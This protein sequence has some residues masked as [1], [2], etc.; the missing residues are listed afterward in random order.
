MKNVI[1]ERF[2]CRTRPLRMSSLLCSAP[3]AG[4]TKLCGVRAATPSSSPATS[5]PS[6][7][8]QP[9]G[10]ACHPSMAMRVSGYAASA[11]FARAG[12]PQP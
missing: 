11:V 2:L 5:P 1:G 7:S 8:P 12:G 3:G 10:R 6:P 4:G 9:Q